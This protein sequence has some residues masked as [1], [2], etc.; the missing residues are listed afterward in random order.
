MSQR[1]E[2]QLARAL[3]QLEI[4]PDALRQTLTDHLWASINATVEEYA[5][6]PAQPANTPLTVRNNTEGL[7]LITGFVAVVPGNATGQLQ[8][9][10]RIIYLPAGVTSVSPTRFLLGPGDTRALTAN[11]AGPMSLILWGEQLPTYGV[12]AR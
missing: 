8:L 10:P 12:M 5:F 11:G 9:G 6:S 7:E 3:E 1:I 4:V 2:A